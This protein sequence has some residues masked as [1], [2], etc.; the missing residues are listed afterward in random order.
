MPLRVPFTQT[1]TWNHRFYSRCSSGRG[2]TV[3]LAPPRG[4]LDVN[5]FA[6]FQ[7][8]TSV[9]LHCDNNAVIYKFSSFYQGLQY[10]FKWWQ[11]GSAACSVHDTLFNFFRLA[12]LLTT[13]A[14]S[15]LSHYEKWASRSFLNIFYLIN[16]ILIV[17]WNFSLAN[18]S[19]LSFDT[20]VNK[21]EVR[22]H[23]SWL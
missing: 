11:G 23:W 15:Y 13:W 1:T 9:V 2:M 19:I 8:R 21:N 5:L 4:F 16:L 6:K 20:I 22:Y 10:S 17:M 3:I 7:F 18:L 12:L 14:F